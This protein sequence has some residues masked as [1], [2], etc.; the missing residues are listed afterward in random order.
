MKILVIGDL[1]GRMPRIHFKDFD[2]IVQVGDVCDDRKIGILYKKYF[3]LLKKK[4]NLNLGWEE[5]VKKEIGK[6]KY[7]SYERES[8]RRGNEILKYLDSFGK[9]IF[10]VP[11]NWD[12]SYGPSRIKDLDKNLYSYLKAFY[13]WYLGDRTNPSLVKGVKNLIDCPYMLHK[14]FGI[15]F[16]GYG[17]VSG[18]ESI[19]LRKKKIVEEVSKKDYEKLKKAHDK[20]VDKLS[21]VFRRRKKDFPTIFI[22]HDVPHGTKLDLIKDKK[23]YAY[24]KHLGSSIA[25]TMCLRYKPLLCIGGH[26]HEGYGKDKI[27]KTT[28]INA[29][30]GKDAQVL[31]DLDEKKGKIRKIN[32]Y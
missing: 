32:F 2:C 8:L 30:Y 28:V 14:K 18:Y 22:S 15:N 4:E 31:I 3:R 6:R 11:G 25:R 5:F 7:D 26:V 13:D 9:P 10:F 20:I 16:I 12:Q 24:G 29:G 27:G 1:H 21:S 17:L 23:N 19:S